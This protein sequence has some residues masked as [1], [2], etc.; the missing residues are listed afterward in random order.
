MPDITKGMRI[1][2]ETPEIRLFFS[3]VTGVNYLSVFFFDQRGSIRVQQTDHGLLTGCLVV[4]NPWSFS[5]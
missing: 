4:S 2:R 5:L 1:R 3:P